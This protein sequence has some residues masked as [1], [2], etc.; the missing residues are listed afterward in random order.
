[1][2]SINS[3]KETKFNK[4]DLKKSKKRKKKKKKQHKGKDR[5]L[6]HY[7]KPKQFIIIQLNINLKR[8]QLTQVV[9]GD[10]P[11]GDDRY[12]DS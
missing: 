12:A 7:S 6:L 5:E 2:Q 9:I 8:N 1:V 3:Q 4:F 10:P 11:E